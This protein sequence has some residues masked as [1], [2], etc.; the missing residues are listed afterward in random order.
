MIAFAFFI[1]LFTLCWVLETLL[2][3]VEINEGMGGLNA[4]ALLVEEKEK[5]KVKEWMWW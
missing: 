4:R 2:C 1:T 3:C 5:E